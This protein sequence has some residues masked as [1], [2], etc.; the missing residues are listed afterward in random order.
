LQYL[1]FEPRN[2]AGGLD[3]K[4]GMNFG[5][6]QRRL[7]IVDIGSPPDP[8]W[9]AASPEFI[10]LNLPS[11]IHRRSDHPCVIGRYLD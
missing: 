6:A 9:S 3:Q 7:K 5:L 4:S 10:T 2:G 11:D 1:F 8:C